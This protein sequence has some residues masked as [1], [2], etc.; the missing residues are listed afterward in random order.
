MIHLL[1]DEI[2]TCDVSNLPVGLYFINGQEGNVYFTKRFIIESA[3]KKAIFV[4][5][6]AE[7][8]F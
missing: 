3:P 6:E 7:G 1:D 4:K 8:F 2:Y 5:I